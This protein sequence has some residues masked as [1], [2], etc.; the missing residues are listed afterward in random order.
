MTDA[1]AGGSRAAP[2]QVLARITDGIVALDDNLQYTYV[3]QRAELILGTSSDDLLGKYA[4]TDA[5]ELTDMIDEQQVEDALSAGQRCVLET[6]HSNLERWFEVH[7]HPD[8]TGVTLYFNDVTDRKEEETSLRSMYRITADRDASLSQKLDQLLALGQEYLDLSYG[9]LSRISEDE[10]QI[11]QASGGHP[12]IQSG[13]TCPLSKAYCRKTIQR[14]DLLAVQNAPNEGWKDDP[15]YEHHE[16]GAYIGSKVI[17]EGELY[18]T[19][20]FADS[21]PRERP[22]TERERSVLE[23]MTLWTGYEL[24]QR[25][26]QNQLRRQNEWLDE[27]ASVLSHDLRNP[28]N[29]ALGHTSIAQDKFNGG[30]EKRQHLR[31]TKQA[32][33]RMETIIRDTLVLSRRDATELEIKPIES[34]DLVERCWE[35]VATE[36]ASLE[37]ED[38]FTLHGDADQLRHV[39]ENLFRNAVEHS[40][41][42]V[43]IRVGQ[44][45]EQAF[46]VEDDGPGIPTDERDAVFEPGHS[47]ADD[48]SG[49]GLTIIQRIADAHDWTVS[50]TDSPEGGARF[51][52]SGV[53]I[54]SA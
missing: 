42:H 26:A 3:N 43:T 53:E 29:V 14:D 44:V 8:D 25:H 2:K 50:V 27:F 9:F 51:E 38:A 24:E 17:V 1:N 21:A 32:L 49:L 40:D 31:K 33:A 39:L 46:Y 16:L 4:W 41:G 52:F 23:L 54:V 18:G 10:Q 5:P 34:A 35:M 12:T 19:F 30:E 45:D 48:G 15:A 7:V 28:L 11:V 20:C 37:I 47:S 36:D 6:Y 13:A 22:F